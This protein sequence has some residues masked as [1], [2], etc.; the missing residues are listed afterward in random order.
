M[1]DYYQ[2]LGVDKGISQEDL[3]KTYRKL[4][5]VHHP[6]RG[7]DEN[8]FK[9]ISEAYDTLGDTQKRQQYDQKQSNPFAGGEFFGGGDPFDMLNKMFNKERRRRPRRGSNLHLH[10]RVT[11]RDLYLGAK[12]K[13]KYNREDVCTPCSGTGGD[14]AGCNHCNG[15]GKIRQMLRAGMLQQVVESPCPTCNGAGKTPVNLCPHCVGRGLTSKTEYFDF[16]L[17]KDLR[18]GEHFTYPGFGNRIK[19]GSPGNLIVDIEVEPVEGFDYEG[20]DLIT[21]ANIGPL[22]IFL[23]K[24]INVNVFDNH[25]TFKLKPYFDPH[26][27]YILRGKGLEGKFGKGNLIVHLKLTTPPNKLGEE[28]IETLKEIRKVLSSE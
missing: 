24:T 26:Q 6:D 8:R 1:K 13:I 11:L 15:S 9:D 14:W 20:D 4:S 5:K 17:N 18:P 28:N 10:I 3:K 22:D 12:K 25:L 7:G 21:E 16:L 19:D 27:K 2:I 23:G